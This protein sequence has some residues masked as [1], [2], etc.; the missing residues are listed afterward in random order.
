MLRSAG[1]PPYCGVPSGRRATSFCNSRDALDDSGLG[2]VGQGGSLSHSPRRELHAVGCQV[3]RGRTWPELGEARPTSMSTPRDHSTSPHATA[4]R[5]LALDGDGGLSV[6]RLHRVLEGVDETTPEIRALVDQSLTAPTTLQRVRAAAL[7]EVILSEIDDLCTSDYP[8]WINALR[9]GFKLDPN[10]FQA[11]AFDNLDRRLDLARINGE[12]G[13]EASQDDMRHHW[14]TGVEQLAHALDARLTKLAE[15][16]R[17]WEPYLKA[18][19][20]YRSSY[21]PSDAQPVYVT[22]LLATY[23]LNGRLLHEAVTERTIIAAEDYVDYYIVRASAPLGARDKVEINAALNCRPSGPTRRV[24]KSNGWISHERPMLLARRLMEGEESFFATSV[25]GQ[26]NQD[27]IVETVVTNHGIEAGGLTMRVQ[28][29]RKDHPVAA[30]WFAECDEDAR[31]VPPPDGDPRR[32]P[33]T[34][35]G[36]LTHTFTQTCQ[37]GQRYGVAW[38][39]PNDQR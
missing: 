16:P 14:N 36:Y 4:L 21:A 6:G 10:R 22:R 23:R 35:F 27:P 32:L 34:A 28:F 7:R 26:R 18:A 33:W 30:W 20:Q 15:N 11:E 1:T 38:Q 37:P 2:R 3:S 24:K 8:M 13:H 5:Q 17:Y 12:F 25:R 29:D 19:E 39:W 9:A 31:T